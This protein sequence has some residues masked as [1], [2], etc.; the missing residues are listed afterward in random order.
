MRVVLWSNIRQQASICG[1][2]RRLQP[3]LQRLLIPLYQQLGRVETKIGQQIARKLY[4]TM[5]ALTAQEVETLDRFALGKR[6]AKVESIRKMPV[7][8]AKERGEMPGTH[9][10]D[11]TDDNIP[12]RKAGVCHRL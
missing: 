9:G 8:D 7:I 4:Q 2:V 11:M 1:S 5:V 6:E 12:E 3:Y 10:T